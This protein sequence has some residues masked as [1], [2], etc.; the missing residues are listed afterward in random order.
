MTDFKKDMVAIA[1]GVFF[2]ALFAHSLGIYWPLGILAGGAVGYVARLLT[3]P[4]RV[5]SAAER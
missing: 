5:V 3:E 2:G 1:L 4:M